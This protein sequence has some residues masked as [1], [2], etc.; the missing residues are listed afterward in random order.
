M[1]GSVKQGNFWV[2]DNIGIKK[3]EPFKVKE[4]MRSLTPACK[5]I[6]D[7]TPLILAL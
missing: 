7:Q 4:V 2:V 1:K 5:N 6:Q 3:K